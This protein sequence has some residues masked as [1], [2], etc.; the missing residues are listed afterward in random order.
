MGNGYILVNQMSRAFFPSKPSSTHCTYAQEL[1]KIIPKKDKSI[2]TQQ[3]MDNI[4]VLSI[5]HED[6][7]TS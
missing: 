4:P 2:N 3:L 6:E 5:I 1:F 7:I